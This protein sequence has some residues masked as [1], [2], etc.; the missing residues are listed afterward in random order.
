MLDVGNSIMWCYSFA[1]LPNFLFIVYCMSSIV[2][3]KKKKQSYLLYVN[4]THWSNSLY[5]I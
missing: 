2:P 5:S 1:I 4:G 3:F